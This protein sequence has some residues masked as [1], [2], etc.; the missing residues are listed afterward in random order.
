MTKTTKSNFIWTNEH[1]VAFEAIKALVVG[2]NCLTV[3]DHTNPRHNKIF[4]TCDASDWHTGACL[5]FGKTW[6]TAQPVAY[7]SMQLGTAEKNYPIHEKELL[8]IVRALKK[9]WSD[10]LG[11]EFVVYTDH[12]TLENFN[13][14]WDLSRCQL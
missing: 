12:R 8:M 2:A 4:I 3:V 14:Q 7:D 13:T 11:S 1:H 9:W 5:S 6:E 10:L